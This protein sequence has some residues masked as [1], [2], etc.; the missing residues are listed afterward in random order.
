MSRQERLIIIFL[1]GCVVVGLSVSFYKRAHLP[2]IRVSPSYIQK[3]SAHLESKILSGRLI[4][5]NTSGEEELTGLLGIGPVLAKNIVAYRQK[6]R[7]F[8][9][10]EEITKVPGIGKAKFERIKDFITTEDE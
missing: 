5:I 1:L 6:V 4:N 2:K 9:F 8:S 3:E 7:L 10:P